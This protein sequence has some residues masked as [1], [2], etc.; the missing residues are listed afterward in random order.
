MAVCSLCSL[1]IFLWYALGLSSNFYKTEPILIKSTPEMYFGFKCRIYKRN[2]LKDFKIKPYFGKSI[3]TYFL[4]ENNSN[5][6]DNIGVKN[7]PNGS[8]TF[9]SRGH[10][11]IPQKC[12]LAFTIIQSKY[13][14]G[15][16]FGSSVLLFWP[17][18]LQGCRLYWVKI[19]EKKL[20]LKLWK[21]NRYLSKIGYWELLYFYKLI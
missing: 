21:I 5:D 10:T 18:S 9:L 1:E 6:F 20:F 17:N 14:F 2:F 13:S 4:T 11:N 19:F 16:S 7:R 12:A 8:L 3:Q 15:K